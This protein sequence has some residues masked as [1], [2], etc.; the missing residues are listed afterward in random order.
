[1]LKG[2][3]RTWI[4]LYRAIFKAL[5]SVA[6]CFICLVHLNYTVRKSYMESA[7]MLPT[8]C[9][10]L[11]ISV[12]SEHVRPWWAT[13]EEEIIETAQQELKELGTKQDG[14]LE[15]VWV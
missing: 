2:K 7:W 1:M 4:E 11:F 6:L 3:D 13:R 15:K 12:V 10:V 8:L 5:C 14:S 9:I